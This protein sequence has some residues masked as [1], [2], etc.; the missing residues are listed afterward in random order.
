MA[1]AISYNGITTLVTP[2]GTATFNASTGD[3]Y[4]IVPAR[5]SGLGSGEVDAEI[6]PKGQADGNIL[7]D[8]FE[9][10]PHLVLAG[11]LRIRSAST[12]SGIVAARDSLASGL[13]TKL[14]TILRATGTLNF[15]NGAAMTI[16]WERICDFP[17]LE[18]IQKGFVFGLVATGLAPT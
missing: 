9:R 1:P 8:F 12:E 2:G 5:S 10:V 7:H 18:G 17:P 4:W 14:R 6:D 13:L 15:S 11:D 16:K 3:T